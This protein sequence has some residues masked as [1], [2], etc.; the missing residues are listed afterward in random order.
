NYLKHSIQPGTLP[1]PVMIFNFKLFGRPVEE[2]ALYDGK[3]LLKAP[4]SQTGYIR[5]N[6]R[7]NFINIQFSGLNYI[8]PE[9][10]YFRY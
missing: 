8:N 9:K 4:L 7:Q 6:H 10:T 1:V 5:L 2:N 3:V